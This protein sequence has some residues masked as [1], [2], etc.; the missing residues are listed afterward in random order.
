MLLRLDK[1]GEVCQTLK[2][3]VKSCSTTSIVQSRGSNGTSG[4]MD[5][6]NV[7]HGEEDAGAGDV[8]QVGIK[9]ASIVA[10]WPTLRGAVD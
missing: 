7:D 4:P 8:D 3:K 10:H 2:A 6:S 9:D 1:I 5:I